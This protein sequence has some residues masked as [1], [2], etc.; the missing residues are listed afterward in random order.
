MNTKI[1]DPRLIVRPLRPRPLSGANTDRASP[2]KFKK[3]FDETLKAGEGLKFSA[4][5][6][7]RL[8]SRRLRLSQADHQT[9]TNAVDRAA[10]KGATDS[11]ILLN[12]LAFVVNIPNRTVVTAMAQ[13]Q[14]QG[15][16]ITNI[17]SAMVIQNQDN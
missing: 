7:R 12:Q 9:L 10:E 2:G 4:H 5:A 1:Q 3:L 11:L 14:M 15:G 13:D 8:E 6:L 16:I 17:D